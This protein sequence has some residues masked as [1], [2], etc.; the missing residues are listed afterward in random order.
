MTMSDVFYC[1]PLSRLLPFEISDIKAQLSFKTETF[2]L[3]SAQLIFQS[4]V[5]IIVAAVFHVKNS[6][7]IIVEFDELWDKLAMVY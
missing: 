2:Y 6:E 5:K 1:R 7:F 4:L 3:A